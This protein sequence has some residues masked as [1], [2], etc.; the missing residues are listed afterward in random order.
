[1]RRI[2]FS[3]NKILFP[4]ASFFHVNHWTIRLGIHKLARRKKGKYRRLCVTMAWGFWKD[5][6]I[7]LFCMRQNC[8]FDK[9]CVC[10]VISGIRRASITRICTMESLFL[11]PCTFYFNHFS[12]ISTRPYNNIS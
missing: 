9:G 3:K 6:W 11:V 10:L 12:I 7:I 8:M 5:S 1:M 4:G 2:Y